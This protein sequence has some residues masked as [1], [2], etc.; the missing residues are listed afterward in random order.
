MSGTGSVKVGVFGI[1]LDTYWP[2]F[3]GLRDRLTGYLARVENRLR[4]LG[5]EI[6]CEG[7]VDS[8]KKAVRPA[9]VFGAKRWISS[10]C[11]SPPMR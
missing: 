10:S 11:T 1:G 3:A 9:A 2:Q 8:V 4:A 6:V 5:A 7:L